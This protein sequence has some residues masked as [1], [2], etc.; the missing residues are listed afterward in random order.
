MPVSACSNLPIRV[1]A[2]PVNAPRS[3]P[4]SSL[5]SSSAGSAAQL[6]LTNGRLRR[7]ERWWMARDD[8]LLA[9]AALAADQHGDVA[10]GDL[11]DHRGDPAHLL[12]VTPDRAIL[13]VAQLLPEVEELGH[14]A[15][16][17]DRVL[18]RNVERDLPETFRIV[19]LDD[20]VGRAEADRFDDRRGLVPAREHDDLRL[21]AGGFERP[22]RGEAVE[23]GHH[24]VEQD[25]RL[26]PRSASSMRAVRRRAC[27]TELHSRATKGTSASSSQTTSRRPQWRRRGSSSNSLQGKM[28]GCTTQPMGSSGN[29]VSTR[30]RLVFKK[31]TS[32]AANPPIGRTWEKVFHVA[33]SSRSATIG[34]Q[35]VNVRVV[36]GTSLVASNVW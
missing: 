1:V 5:S 20:V 8:Q 28:A 26:A 22:Q 32:T 13:V 36:T 31:R 25:R 4:K 30:I 18:D 15:V 21:G 17:L 23:T 10:V 11:L 27:S 24:D 33:R 7:V 9:D 6:T 16:L 19:R 12:A 3:W 14:E 29:T 2:A 34:N 35:R